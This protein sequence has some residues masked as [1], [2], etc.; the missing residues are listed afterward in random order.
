[1]IVTHGTPGTR[2]AKQASSAIPVVMASAG[3]AVLAGF[4]SNLREPDGN[5]TGSTFFAAELAAKR[6]E[7]LRDLMPKIRRI[8]V[9]QNPANSA[10]GPVFGAMALAAATLKIELQP[11]PVRGPGDFDAAFGDRPARIRRGRRAPGLRRRSGRA[12]GARRLFCRQALDRREGQ[13]A[14]DRARHQVRDDRQQPHRARARHHDSEPD[15][16]ARRP[17]DRMIGRRRIVIAAGAA[18]L[19]VPLRTRAQQAAKVHRVGFLGDASASG[20]VREVEAVRAGLR[21]LGHVEGKNLVIE[22]R[23]ADS[24]PERLRAMATELVSLRS[25]VI[26]THG[27][28]GVRAALAATRSIPIVQMDGIDPVSAGLVAS[29][30]RPGGHLTGS[31]S[32]IVE[33]ALKRLEL[34][35]DVAPRIARVGVIMNADHPNSAGVLREM[36]TAPRTLKL[37]LQAFNVRTIEDLPAAFDSVAGAKMEAALIQE[38]PMLNSNAAVVAALAASKRLPAVGFP[39]FADAGGLLAY[40]SNRAAVYGRAAYFVDRILKGAKP[41]DLPFERASTFD[42]VVNRKI[43]KAMGIPIPQ[44][45]LLR[46]T[47]VIE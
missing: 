4:T 43:A 25:E 42:L 33:V 34:L 5:V 19:A 44:T 1:V 35:K 2:A 36:E 39:N 9:L 16:A 40:G 14:A 12:V 3:D 38:E 47:R 17:R 18:L 20:Y 32:F 7:V 26:L 8:A 10:V 27:T 21:E 45:V 13:G 37:T 30:A 29:L 46:A 24:G 31:T 15:R 11:L 6:L 23:W 41:G 28:A 22:F